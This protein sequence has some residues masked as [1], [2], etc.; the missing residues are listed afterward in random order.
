M[1]THLCWRRG[2]TRFVDIPG[3]KLLQRTMVDPN[4]R[5]QPVESPTGYIVNF[6]C[7]GARDCL[8]VVSWVERAQDAERQMR[9]WRAAGGGRTVTIRPRGVNEPIPQS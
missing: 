6:Q 9:G 1:A 3:F 8:P 2:C 5:K 7:G 4:C